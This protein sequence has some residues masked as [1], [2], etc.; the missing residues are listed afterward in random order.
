MKGNLN[1]SLF[2]SNRR[3][4]IILTSLLGAWIVSIPYEG[5][6]LYTLAKNYNLQGNVMLDISL[7]MQVVG[8]VLGGIFIKTINIARKTL[9]FAIPICILCTITF[10]LPSYMVWMIALTTCSTIA[11]IC[12][13]T[14]GHFIRNCIAYSDRFRTAVEVIIIISVLKIVINNISI[15]ISIQIAFAFTIIMLLAALYFTFKMP[16]IQNNKIDAKEFDTKT[17]IKAL[18]LLFLFVAII[19]INFGIMIQTINPKYN[20]LGWLTSWYWLLPY[21]GA[22]FIIRRLKNTDDRS[23]ILYIAIGMIGFGF[24]L[25]LLFDYSVSS[26][27]IVNTVMMGAWAIC[28]VFWWS[29]LGEM[30]EMVKNPAKILSVGFSA[31]MIGVF[32]GK[33]IADN[34]LTIS[35]VNLSIVSMGVICIALF[36]LPILHKLLSKMIKTNVIVNIMETKIGIIN[37]PDGFD[38]LTEREK[39]IVELLLKGRTSKLIAAE[40]YISLNTVKT[41]IKN[42]YSKLGVRRKSDLFKLIIK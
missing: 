3:A 9:I 12:I 27:L 23:H 7:A 25:F 31:V 29:I 2:A 34:N 6:L 15:Y 39:Q 36:I 37:F 33:I 35:T 1:Q 41:H 8:L 42:I 17:G 21:M 20:S 40:L 4:A 13:T 32:I 5:Q 26:Y 24:I 19:S 18:F 11:G 14:T 22:A 10:F 16:S 28:D 38:T 30:L